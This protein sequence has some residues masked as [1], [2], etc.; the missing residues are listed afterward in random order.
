MLQQIA[1]KYEYCS[2]GLLRRLGFRPGGRSTAEH[3]AMRV[4]KLWRHSR[5]EDTLAGYPT[6]VAVE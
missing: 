5:R 2:M 4:P 6:L 3:G 1:D